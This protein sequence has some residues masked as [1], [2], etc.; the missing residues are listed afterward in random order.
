MNGVEALRFTF[1]D[2][3][4]ILEGVMQDVTQEMADFL[5]PNLADP[6]G[7]NYLHAIGT[8]DWAVN[9]VCQGKPLLWQA[10]GWSQKLGFEMPEYGSDIHGW[11]RTHRVPLDLARQ[12]AQAVIQAANV[13]LDTLRDADLNRPITGADSE[14][15]TVGKA[16]ATYINW[17]TA[18]HTGEISVLKGIQSHVGYGF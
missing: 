7:W 11:A 3:V 14:H 6:I 4:G 5:P 15:N 13:Y 12:Y 1:N 2:S 17:H 16:F 18:A 9:S 8:I 10:E